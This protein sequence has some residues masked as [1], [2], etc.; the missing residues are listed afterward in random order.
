M[1]VMRY[2]HGKRVIGVTLKPKTMKIWS[3]SLHICSKLEQDLVCLIEPDDNGK[4]DKYKEESK[5]RIDSDKLDRNSI[6]RKLQEC[7]D[8]MSPN[9]H[10]PEMVNIVLGKIAQEKVNVDRAVELGFII[11]SLFPNFGSHLGCYLHFLKQH[12]SMTICHRSDS[13]RIYMKANN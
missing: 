3:L 12:S 11:L 6:R 10:P 9:D 8:T 4:Q 13:Q 5:G 2:G 1:R 7:I